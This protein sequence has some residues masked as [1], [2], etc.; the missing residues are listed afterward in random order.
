MRTS[1]MK[2]HS[3]NYFNEVGKEHSSA[4]LSPGISTLFTTEKLGRWFVP[5]SGLKEPPECS[6]VATL[7]AFHVC[8]RHGLDFLL[9]ITHHLYGR[10]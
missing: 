7:W 1:L 10:A 3:S 6:V 9:A 4:I 5:A 8:G 2:S